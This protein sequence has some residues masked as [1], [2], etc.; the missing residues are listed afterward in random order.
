[1]VARCKWTQR[2]TSYMKFGQIHVLVF[3]EV[4]SHFISA[5]LRGQLVTANYLIPLN[6]ASLLW[7][8]LDRLCMSKLDVLR[9]NSNRIHVLMVND[10]L[11]R[12]DRLISKGFVL[13]HCVAKSA[14]PRHQK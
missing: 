3:E 5:Q 14:F 7:D 10:L 11:D 2:A 8:F 12:D 9:I 4:P 13:E 1:M 6:L